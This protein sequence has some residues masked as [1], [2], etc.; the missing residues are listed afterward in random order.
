MRLPDVPI[1]EAVPPPK[2]DFPQ[3]LEKVP[4]EGINIPITWAMIMA[5]WSGTVNIHQMGS[6][7]S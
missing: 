5:F 7:A 1:I 4:R 6:N 3:G 2:N